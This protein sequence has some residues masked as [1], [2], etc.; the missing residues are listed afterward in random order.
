MCVTFI[1]NTHHLHLFPTPT[2]C[3]YSQHPPSALRADSCL[4][5]SSP[6]DGQCAGSLQG[7]RSQVHN[8]LHTHTHTSCNIAE[9]HVEGCVGNIAA[10][11]HTAVEVGQLVG[12]AA[13][14]VQAAAVAHAQGRL[15]RGDEVGRDA[16]QLS[17]LLSKQDG[18]LGVGEWECMGCAPART[19]PK[20]AGWLGV[21]EWECTGGVIIGICAASAQLQE[22]ACVELWLHVC[23]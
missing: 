22:W 8:L 10:D 2:I 17:Q 21:G 3:I 23:A 12:A 6:R 1:P 13:G 18:W 15:K 20:Q 14:R 9:I 5:L 16:L 4:P 11:H 7:N 19:A